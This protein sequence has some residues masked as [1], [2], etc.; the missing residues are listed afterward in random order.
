MGNELKTKKTLKMDQTEIKIT[1]QKVSAYLKL[2]LDRKAGFFK[3]KELA[4]A[5]SMRQKY[6]DHSDLVLQASVALKALNIV[7]AASLVIKDIKLIEERTMSIVIHIKNNTIKE[8]DPLLPYIEDVIFSTYHFN[9]IQI[10]E[11][12]KMI[13]DAFGHEIFNQITDFTRVNNELKMLVQ[14]PNHL[15][16]TAYLEEVKNRHKI[17]IDLDSFVSH[18]E[19]EMPKDPEQPY[20]IQMSTIDFDRQKYF[21]IIN[22]IRAIGV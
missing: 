20:D 8:L 14:Q 12:N 22:K 15:Q 16:L 19:E 4:L 11:F 18:K 2:E 13:H 9:L 7:K 21:E 5:T 17:D 6:P 3:S 10:K 1:C